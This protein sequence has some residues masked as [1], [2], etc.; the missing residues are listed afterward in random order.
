MDTQKV[1]IYLLLSYASKS[2][3]SLPKDF[4]NNSLAISKDQLLGLGWW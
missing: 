1:E 3:L 2:H 4:K